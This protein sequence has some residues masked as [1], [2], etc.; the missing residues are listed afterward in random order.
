M[1]ISKQ[2]KENVNKIITSTFAIIQNVYDKQKEVDGKP[3][4]DSKSRIIFPKKRDMTIR[5]SE[6]ELRFIFVEQ[7]N[8]W[9][10]KGWDVYYSVET[11]TKDCYVFTDKGNNN[12][13]R[14]AEKD[15]EGNPL[16]GQSASFDLVIHDVNYKRIALIEFKANNASEND[17]KKDFCKLN[18]EIERNEKEDVEA[19][20][21]FIE[22]L[23][24]SNKQTYSS[25]A[26]KIKSFKGVFR[27]YSLGE[28]GEITDEIIKRQNDPSS[29]L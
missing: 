2:V 9:I 11:P 27:C 29:S 23:T 1:S 22:I 28:K 21:F 24:G 13:P 5:V 20:T 4:E 3:N 19:E 25:I 8:I 18:N 10:K 26:K 7:L 16:E 12:V 14:I 15:K 6:Q 17:H